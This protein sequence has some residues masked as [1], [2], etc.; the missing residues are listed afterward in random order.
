MNLNEYQQK[1]SR[2]A[3]KRFAT[4]ELELAVWALG[5]AGE[6]GEVADYIKKIWVFRIYCLF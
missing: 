4:P 6:S 3:G 5:I 1:A 2:T